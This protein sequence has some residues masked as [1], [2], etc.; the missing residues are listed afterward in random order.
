MEL[1]E[2]RKMA[3][4]EDDMWYYRALH[5]R[6]I[7]WMNKLTPSGS[8]AILDAGCGTGGLLR[9]VHREH[10]AWT[11]TGL[12]FST[13]ACALARERTRA[14][15]VEGSITHLPFPD[16]SFDTVVSGDVLCQV[17][18]DMLALKEITRCVKPGG[19]VIVNVPAYAWLWSY[20][21]VSVHSK[22]RYTRPRLRRMFLEAGLRPQFLSYANFLVF[23]LVVARRKLMPQGSTTSDVKLSAP[24]VEAALRTIA[25]MEFGWMR[26]GIASPCG[27]SVFIAAIKP[28]R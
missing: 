11:L 9:A 10:A 22:Q 3:E 8:A 12:D 28:R 13:V 23:P 4:V 2:Y 21:D 27:S 25:S 1:D 26:R 5:R 24:P 14:T 16:E 6:F 20:H 19:A 7:F 15:I 17:E 18:A